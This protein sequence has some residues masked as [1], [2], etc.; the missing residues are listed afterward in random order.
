MPD[1]FT[2]MHTPPALAAAIDRFVAA[3]WGSR[4]SLFTPG[5]D[6]WT[7]E[8]LDDLHKRFVQNPDESKASFTD[9]FKKQLEGA[10]SDCI[11]TC[12]RQRRRAADWRAE[13]EFK[14]EHSTSAPA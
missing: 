2:R 14:H 12:Q 1:A 10:P 3:A 7:P 9:K 6:I 13:S 8:N 4:D 11:T 5:K